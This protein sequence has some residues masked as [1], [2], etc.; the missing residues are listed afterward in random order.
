MHIAL[1]VAGMILSA[2]FGLVGCFLIYT[3]VSISGL[4]K[5]PWQ[6]DEFRYLDTSDGVPVYFSSLTPTILGGLGVKML[7]IA[8]AILALRRR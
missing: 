1:G 6:S 2:G 5:A 4:E 3:A 8:T 7:V